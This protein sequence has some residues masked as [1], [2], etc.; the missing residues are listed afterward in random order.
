MANP[1]HIAWLNEGVRSWN[2]RRQSQSFNPDLSSEDISRALGGHAREDIRQISV[3]LRDVNL[4][5]ADLSNSTLR[6]TDLTGAKFYIA[7]L[8]NAKLTGSDVTGAQLIGGTSRI[9][10]FHLRQVSQDIVPSA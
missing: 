6:D 3:Q 10:R 5:G 8:A 7:N 4:S 2:A 1:Q 9:A